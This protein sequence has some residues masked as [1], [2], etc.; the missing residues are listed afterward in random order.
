M[1]T[2]QSFNIDTSNIKMDGESKDLTITSSSKAVF[3]LEIIKESNGSYYNFQTN[4]FQSTKTRLSN[5]VETSGSYKKAIKFPSGGGTAQKYEIFLFAEQD[6]KHADYREV[7]FLDGSMDINSTVGSNSRLIK[8]EIYQTADVTITIN[9][10]SPNGSV[11]FTNSS[12]SIVTPVGHSRS[13][14]PFSFA[15][16]TAATKALTVKRQPVSSDIMSFISATVGDA[17]PIPGENNYP[18]ASESAQTVNGAITSGAVVEIDN[19]VSN[20]VFIGDKITAPVTTDTVNATV[21]SGTSVTM[22]NATAGKMAVG[23]RVTGNAALE[24]SIVT[25]ASIGTG[26]NAN[27]FNLSEAV[28]IAGGITLTFSSKVNRS[29][30]VVTLFSANAKQF[31]MSQDIQFRD[32][33]ILTFANQRNHRWELSSTTTDLSKITAGMIHVAIDAFEPTALVSDYLEQITI[34]EN[35]LGEYKVDKVRLPAI[36]LR[37]IKPVISRDADTKIVTTT[38]GS[39]TNPI[40]IIFSQQAHAAF[41]GISAK[42]YAYGE[43]KIKSLTDYDV[44]FS[45]LKVVLS[46]VV[47]Q[48]SSSTI[49]SSSTTVG[50]DS[51]NGIVD[52]IST[53]SGL[54]ISASAVNPT[55]SSG[56]GTVSGAG[57]IVLS[58]AQELDDNTVLTFANTSTVATVTGNIKINST[59]DK[60]V[61][62]RFD[63]EKFLQ[64][65]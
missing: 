25:V 45:D 35:E 34:F 29:A 19:N 12:T 38:Y 36:D 46:P 18:N 32:N 14:I 65:H 11:A 51:R 13:K 26:G 40:H 59:S 16:S 54:G 23:D 7:R 60:A 1:E 2:I 5:H 24:R 21:G 43:E 56:A 49:G 50:V 64:M 62:I 4:L 52:G 37:A 28:E 53:V 55:V 44:E 57:N 15:V 61:T 42:L 17:V 27:K 9:G 6:T 10:Y 31:A 63:V 30:T 20:A 3:S 33:A 48:T 41:K 39:S 22:N 58:A 47:T 8:K